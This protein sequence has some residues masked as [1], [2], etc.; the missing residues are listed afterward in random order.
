MISKIDNCLFVHIP[1]VA[2]QSI[3]SIFIERAGLTWN[4]RS[5]L[6]LRPNS[7]PKMGPPRLSHLTANEYVKYGYL[8]LDEYN[9]LYSFSFVRNPWARL[10]S[11]YQ[12]RKYPFSF[13]DFLFKHF[14][15]IGDDNYTTFEDKHRHIIPQSE[16][17][18]DENDK[19]LVNFIG[20][21]ENL[22]N[23]FSVVS[24][25]ITGKAQTLPHKN[26]T[27]GFISKIFRKRKLNYQEAYSDKGVEFVARYYARDI[28]LFNYSFE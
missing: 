24:E 1:K 18:F 9:K 10:F 6:L 26:K 5:Q 8:S 2:G 23:D 14:P 4:T 17:I 22:D 27:N 3:E 21:F 25:K 20:R 13:E 28:A 11:E 7:E 16:F 15:S 19:C 12:Y